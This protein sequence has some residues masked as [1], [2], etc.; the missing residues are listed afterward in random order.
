MSNSTEFNPYLIVKIDEA[1]V[2]L[3]TYTVPPFLLYLFRQKLEQRKF[4]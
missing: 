2:I 3:S 4:L 1:C